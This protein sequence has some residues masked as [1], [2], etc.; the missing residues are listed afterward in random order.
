MINNKKVIMFVGGGTLGSV[1]PLLNVWKGLSKRTSDYDAVWVG[2]KKGPEVDQVLPLGIKYYSVASGKLRRYF[3]LKNITDPF[4][5]IIA[6][7]Q[8]VYLLTKIKPA[9]VVGAG[10]FVQVPLL[11]VAFCLRI[12]TIIYQMDVKTGL[13]NL[14]SSKTATAIAVA[15]P[16]VTYPWKKDKQFFVGAVAPTIKAENKGEGVVIFGGGTGAK[17]INDMV[18]DLVSNMPNDW[19]VTHIC[20]KGKI[21][22]KLINKD[23]YVQHENLSNQEMLD[24]IK[25]SHVIVSRAGMGALFEIGA[26]GK[27]AIIIPIAKSHQE[28]NA[29]Y[30]ARKNAVIAINQAELNAEILI[31][32]VVKIVTGNYPFLQ[33]NIATIT[34]YDG[35]DKLGALILK[36][37]K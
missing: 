7:I 24:L 25:N 3:S 32:E 6:I 28:D 13:T 26:F 20:G 34:S 10:S 9:V 19:K 1:T 18:V 4:K 35:V 31:K 21:N 33:K 29:S 27:P 22:K 14:L 11:L 37:V 12:P 15:L 30:Y 8:S 2:T 36:H 17:I 16:D 23:N 5:I